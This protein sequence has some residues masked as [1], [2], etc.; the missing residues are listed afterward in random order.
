MS[1]QVDELALAP[2]RAP[3]TTTTGA[4]SARAAR[5]R[6][7]EGARPSPAPAGGPAADARR[8]ARVVA[9]LA[10]LGRFSFVGTVAFFVDLGLFNLLRFG[11][12]ETLTASPLEAKAIAVTV[13]TLVSW[14]GSR[15]WTFSDRR[16]SRHGR[17][18]ATFLLVNAVG[19]AISLGVLAFS[20]NVLGLTSPLAENV[21]AN[22]V[23]LALAN[24]FR[25][26]AYRRLVFTGARQGVRARG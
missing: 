24:A 10:E 8:R 14:L 7:A 3:A 19:M 18:L 21:A 22:V 1:S 20:T 6:S 13:A 4:R 12:W 23:G 11:P 15:Y 26:V 17:E 2:V 25:Y 5:Q 9:R 16:T